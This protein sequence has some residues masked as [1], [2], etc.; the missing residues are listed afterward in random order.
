MLN[1]IRTQQIIHY[2]WD[3]TLPRSSS[4]DRPVF[5]SN[6]LAQFWELNSVHRLLMGSS[7]FPRMEQRI[8]TGGFVN[9]PQLLSQE[10]FGF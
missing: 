2:E 3:S 7:V 5:K 1:R 9:L 10:G 8:S 6:N 4:L